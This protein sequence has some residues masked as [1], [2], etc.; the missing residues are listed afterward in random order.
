MSADIEMGVVEMVLFK[1]FSSNCQEAYYSPNMRRFEKVVEWRFN[2]VCAT[3]PADRSS[4]VRDWLFM[5]FGSANDMR[6]KEC[7]V[8][9]C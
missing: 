2:I 3:F 7:P 8:Q 6:K 5:S 4:G 9:N 1:N